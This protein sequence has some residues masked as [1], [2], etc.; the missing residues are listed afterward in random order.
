MMLGALCVLYV[1][2]GAMAF[3]MIGTVLETYP[4]SAEMENFNEARIVFVLFWPVFIWVP[5][6]GDLLSRK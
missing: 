1:S 6:I 2:G 4:E 5:F 3:Y